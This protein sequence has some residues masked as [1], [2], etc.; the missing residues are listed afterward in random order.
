MALLGLHHDLMSLKSNLTK[1]F[2]ES[3]DHPSQDGNGRRRK[4]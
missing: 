1:S 4:W 2:E 3:Q